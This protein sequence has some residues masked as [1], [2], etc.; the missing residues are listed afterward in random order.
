LRFEVRDHVCSQYQA[1]HSWDVR[2]GAA[3]R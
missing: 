1:V 2:F 3:F